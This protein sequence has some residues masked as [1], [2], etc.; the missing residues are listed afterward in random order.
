MPRLWSNV[1]MQ[2]IDCFCAPYSYIIMFNLV[3]SYSLIRQPPAFTRFL[4]IATHMK[5]HHARPANLITSSV[6]ELVH[7]DRKKHKKYL[8]CDYSG[9]SVEGSANSGTLEVKGTAEIVDSTV[10]ASSLTVCPTDKRVL[11]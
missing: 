3:A 7:D 9:G 4:I 8:P 5:L 6:H 11:H 10:L 2:Y 1:G